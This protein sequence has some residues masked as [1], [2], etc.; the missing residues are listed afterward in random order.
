MSTFFIYPIEHLPNNNNKQDEP[1]AAMTTLSS[2]G[3]SR[4]LEIPLS[5]LDADTNQKINNKNATDQLFW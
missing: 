1:T 3:L 4:I 5:L 2:N